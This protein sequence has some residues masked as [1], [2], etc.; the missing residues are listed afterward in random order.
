MTQQKAICHHAF[1][2]PLEVLQLEEVARPEPS[3][4]EVRVRLLAATINPSD[5][6]MIGGSYGRLRELPAVA[7]REGVGVVD[8]IGH[9]VSRIGVGARVRFPDGGAWQETACIPAADVLAVPED[10]SIEQ[11]AI[12]FINPPTAYCLLKKI[13]NL[14]PGSWVLQNAGNSAVGLSVIQMAKV[15]GLKTISQVRREALIEPLQ[16]L[17]AD[18]V[19][20]EGSGWVEQVNQLTEG[21]SI[22]LALN[23]IGGESAMHQIK[24]LGESGT[25]VTFGGMVGDLVR[26]PTRYLIFNNVRMVGFWWDQWCQRA[27]KDGLDEVMSAVYTMMREGTLKLPV[28][29]TYSFAEY[30]RALKH[31][32]SPRLGKILLKP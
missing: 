4:G 17:G 5:Y 27:G 20:I 25:Q 14:A 30:E 10:V 28:E 15:L 6:G 16:A 13:V 8:A 11:A 24:V 7:G 3:D 21:E 22:R 19:V 26:F 1:G 31:D 2:K 9:G 32:K 18:R 23:S 29:A 12:S